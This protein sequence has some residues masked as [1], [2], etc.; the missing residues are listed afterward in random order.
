MIG[1]DLADLSPFYDEGEFARPCQWAPRNGDPVQAGS[2]LFA[3]EDDVTGAHMG[4]VGRTTTIRYPA[5]QFE[6]LDE[7]EAVQ[8]GGLFYVVRRVEAIASGL[9]CLA[10]LALADSP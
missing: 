2:V 8:I 1:E 3:S 4:A 6:G 10:T 7:G 9:E 5:T